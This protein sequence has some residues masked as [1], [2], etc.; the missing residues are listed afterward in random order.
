MSTNF[1]D[2]DG[3]LSNWISQ[4]EAA[5]IH[6]VSRQAIHKL[7]QGGRLRSREIGGR[8][9]VSRIDLAAFS[10]LA[11]G[12]P[13][14]EDSRLLKK[15]KEMLLHCSEEEMLAIAEFLQSKVPPH[16]L[17]SKLGVPIEMILGALE[18][19]SD[20]TLRMFKGVVAEAAFDT[21]V[22]KHLQNW[23]NLPITGN[24]AYD[25]FLRDSIGSVSV[26]V[27]LQRKEEGGPQ[28]TRKSNRKLLPDYFVVETQRTRGGTDKKTGKSTRPYRFGQFD[29]LAV[30]M[31]PSTGKWDSFLYT[32]ES[33]LIPDDRHENFLATH[34]PIALKPNEDWTD[35]FETC[36]RWFRSRIEKTIQGKVSKAPPG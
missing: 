12:R 35:D 18:R 11:P 19:A 25:F 30:S 20:L 5:R 7:V 2:D 16:P 32:V 23:E 9:L 28:R 6:G 36:V 26:Q 1:R 13:R 22:V 27:K 10:P 24:P 29:I 14:N 15:I 34:Q 17:E 8:T 3:D 31:Q 4:A 21:Y 33:W